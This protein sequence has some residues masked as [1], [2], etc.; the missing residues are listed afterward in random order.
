MKLRKSA[1]LLLVLTL[2]MSM[3]L[4]ACGGGNTAT[5][6]PAGEE[7]TDEETA[8][9]TGEP[10]TGGDLIVGSIGEP[11]LFNALYSTDV[12]SSDIEGFIYNGLVGGDT[13]FN[14]VNDLAT[15]VQMSED[16]LTFTVKLREDVKWHDGEQFNADDV[17][18]TFSVP[19]DPDYAGERGSAF[20]SLESVTKI[21]DYTVEFKLNQ[22][23]AT[24]HSITLSYYILPEHILGDVPVGDLGEHEFNTKSPIGT[25]PFKFDEWRDGEYVRVVANEDYFDGR[26]YLDSITYKIVPDQ[27]AL[28]AQLQAGDIDFTEVPGTDV[29]TVKSFPGIKVESGLGLSYTFL[30]FNLQQERF[31]DVKVRQA[32]THA[33]DRQAIVDSVMN[34][35]GEVAHLPESP[36]SW[37]YNDDVPTFEYDPEKAKALLAEAG[38]E[39]TDGDGILDKDGEPFSFTIKTNQGNKIR[40]D[41]IVVLQQQFKEVGIEAKPEIVEW[42]AYI[43]QI[44][45][46]N[47]DFDAMVLGWSMSTFPDQYDIFH[48]SQREAGLNMH[49]YSNAEAD[50]LMEEAR[51]ILDQDEYKEIYGEIYKILAE[52]QAYTFLYYPNV[53]RAMP[54]KVQGYEFHAKSEFYNIHKWWIAE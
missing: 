13:E 51:Q 32:M 15:D 22:V 26:P 25:G 47:W 16:G 1:W 21:D 44:S 38:W 49:W 43:E 40:E 36:L 4:A 3:F 24:F 33:I 35:D 14:P 42:S 9:P 34:G 6:K 41:I 53:H 48:T 2:A 37:A 45:A 20:E 8:A 50:K 23:D 5:E 52:E 46:P 31:N 29:D 7:G 28:L 11:T 19:K 17:V 10:V 27:N 18:F 12:S 30:A 54:E 39:D